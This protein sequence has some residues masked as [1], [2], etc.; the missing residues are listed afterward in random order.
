LKVDSSFIDASN[1][2]RTQKSSETNDGALKIASLSRLATE[3]WSKPDMKDAPIYMTL[4]DREVTDYL[5]KSGFEA[6]VFPFHNVRQRRARQQRSSYFQVNQS[7][8][9]AVGKSG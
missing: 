2:D 6:R 1:T 7:S 3:G 5:R 9:L 8:V 4:S